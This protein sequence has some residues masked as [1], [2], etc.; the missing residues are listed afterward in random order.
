MIRTRSLTAIV[1]LIT[2]MQAQGQNYFGNP[3]YNSHAD[4]ITTAVNEDTLQKYIKQLSG[5]LTINPTGANTQLSHRLSGTANFR[6]AAEHIAM[7]FRTYGLQTTIENNASP[8]DRV[9]VVGTL[10]GTSSTYVIICGHF[11]SANQNCPGADDNGSGT[12]AV[13]EAA[14]ILSQYKFYYTIKFIAWGGE[15]QGLIGS[16]D[17]AAKHPNDSIRAVVNLDMIMWDGDADMILQLHA[18][19]NAPPQ[20]SDDLAKYIVKID[21]IYN[22]PLVA[23]RI[24]Q[25]ITASDH[26]AFW[27]INKS[28]VLFIEE[29]GSDFNPYYHKATDTFANASGLQHQIFFFN[30]VR[31]GLASVAHLAGVQQPV[32][33]EL[34]SF[35]AQ[36]TGEGV[37]LHWTTASEQNNHGFIIQKQS[38]G[39]PFRD[40]GFVAGAGTTSTS[41]GYT[42]IDRTITASHTSYRLKQIDLDGSFAF[43]PIVTVKHSRAADVYALSVYP[44]PVSITRDRWI[45]VSGNVAAPGP[46]TVRLIDALGRIVAEHRQ[47][48][49]SEKNF[50]VRFDLQ[51]EQ[52][53]FASGIYLLSTSPTAQNQ[54]QRI[55]V[56]Q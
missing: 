33:V 45:N 54:V 10:P 47:E 6:T 5:V 50:V 18:K 14:R 24:P 30:C 40:I 13:L 35:T 39:A 16:K 43:S 41:H 11:D 56:L 44:S 25:G 46:V 22:N 23:V 52:H 29:Y 27:N 9:N 26:A 38:G 49:G 34:V 37:A 8:W 19:T 32:P 21:S 51:T 36:E 12:A 48:I 53:R 15:E 7:Q 28:A 4:N 42:F 20:Y 3:A 31:L 2:L 1:V 55:L 17:Y